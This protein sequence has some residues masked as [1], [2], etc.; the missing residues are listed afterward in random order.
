[1][2]S[3]FNPKRIS[4]CGICSANIFDGEHICVASPRLETVF[5]TKV[6]VNTAKAV[7]DLQFN[8][9]LY[10]INPFNGKFELVYDN[11][12]LIVQATRGL[13]TFQQCGGLYFVRYQTTSFKKFSIGIAVNANNQWRLMYR[14]DIT[15]RGGINLI[16]MEPEVQ[17]VSNDFTRNDELKLNTVAIF[18]VSTLPVQIEMPNENVVYIN[19]ASFDEVSIVI[20]NI[21]CVNH[22]ISYK[23]FE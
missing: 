16:K 20:I 6:Y 1:M 14:A 9:D 5:R 13:F 2:E 18:G 4:R 12:Q 19:D 3:G 11:Q 7:F 23:C 10:C 8:G 17:S 21:F 22:L 15:P